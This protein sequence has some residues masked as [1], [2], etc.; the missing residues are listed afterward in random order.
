M[1]T[2]DAW[3]LSAIRSAWA[4]LISMHRKGELR[5]DGTV[6]DRGAHDGRWPCLATEAL[7]SRR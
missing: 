5:I 6:D 1:R 7:G 2:Q 4:D 3:S